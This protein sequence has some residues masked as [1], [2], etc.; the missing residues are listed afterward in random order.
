MK[1][2]CALLLVLPLLLCAAVAEKPAYYASGNTISF[3]WDNDNNFE[4]INLSAEA[5]TGW[6]AEIG[7][8]TLTVS[9]TSGATRQMTV[10]EYSLDGYHNA[11]TLISLFPMRIGA[12]NYLYIETH[13]TGPESLY[14]SWR[15]IAYDGN[16]FTCPIAVFDPG[17]TSSVALMRGMD[18]SDPNAAYVYSAGFETY[19]EESYKQALQFQFAG[20][21]IAFHMSE[22]PF[23]GKYRA[24]TATDS[25][26]GECALRI[27]H[28]DLADGSASSV[29][30]AATRYKVTQKGDAYIR[31]SPSLNAPTLI[32]IKK[33]SEAEYL[34]ESR[35]D[36]RTVAWHHVS[37]Q[38]YS[39]WAS[40]KY[41]EFGPVDSLVPKS[42]KGNVSASG[43]MHVREDADTKANSLGVIKKGGTVKFAGTAR[44]DDRGVVWFCVTYNGKNGWV[45]SKYGKLK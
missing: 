42:F 26:N 6:M 18:T 38:G 9:E 35:W 40:S 25:A 3:D 41:S 32:V 23:S 12:V 36:D 31:S 27:S 28:M 17:F 21:G 11:Q 8:V 33:G 30:P 19:N 44:L 37:Y 5:A 15:L 24:L 43:D 14:S 29:S 45:S 1:R 10:L 16:K 22:L 39:G 34:G 20:T 2:I 13:A 4:S 7:T